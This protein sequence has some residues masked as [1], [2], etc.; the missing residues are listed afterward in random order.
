[1]TKGE[2]TETKKVGNS[3][4]LGKI[5]EAINRESIK[6]TGDPAFQSLNNDSGLNIEC[7]SSGSMLLDKAL[8]RGV[9]KGRV[10]EIFG[11]E[12]S[13]KTTIALNIIRHFQEQGKSAVFFDAE[14]AFSQEHARNLGVSTEDEV[15]YFSQMQ[16]AE[17]VLKTIEEL[18]SLNTAES[19]LGVIVVDSVASLASNAELDKGAGGDPTVGSLS[20]VMSSSLRILVGKA[21]KAGV[22]LIM[23]NQIRDKIG[24]MYGD[25][26][27]TPGGKAL[28]FYA[29][30][31]V[32]TTIRERVKDKSGDV[33]GVIVKCKVVKNK[34]APPYREAEVKISYMSGIDQVHEIIS[35]VPNSLVTKNTASGN[36]YIEVETGMVIGTGKSSAMA[37]LEEDYEMRERILKRYY[38]GDGEAPIY[39][40]YEEVPNAKPIVELK[41][42][43][44]YAT[45]ESSML[46]DNLKAPLLVEEDD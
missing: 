20:R 17:G 31:R 18:L 32:K 19:N 7:V 6:K 25:P 21:H 35:T 16:S 44:P 33:T 29:S 45:T 9:P 27:T 42:Q 11:P 1:M 36:K 46:L 40:S 41:D 13:G 30:V 4:A 8:G 34:I 38:E 2:K 3:S 26:E 37:R 15:F 24:V 14:H 43:K 10:I 23:L 39:S 22:T 12:S 5:I 28:K